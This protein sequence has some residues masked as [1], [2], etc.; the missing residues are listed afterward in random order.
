METNGRQASKVCVEMLVILENV[1]TN[2]SAVIDAKNS[3][4]FHRSIKS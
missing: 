1:S 4:E 3:G 2:Q